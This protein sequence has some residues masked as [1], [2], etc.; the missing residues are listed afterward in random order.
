MMLNPMMWKLL[1]A[2]AVAAF[3][4]ITGAYVYGRIDAGALTEAAVE[5]ALGD[6]KSNTED[7]INELAEEAD[8]ARLRRRECRARR[9]M[10]WSFANNEC[11]KAE[12]QSQ[13]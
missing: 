4:L 2:A 3:F 1:A 5:R 7:A 8:R 6:A 13:R 12:T 9:G 11:V 10:S